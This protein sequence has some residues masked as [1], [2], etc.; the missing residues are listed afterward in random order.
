MNKAVSGVRIFHFFA[1]VYFSVCL[2]LLYYAA[3]YLVFN[4]FT[5][6]AIVSLGIEGFVYYI[7]NKANCPLIHVQ[8]KINDPI[9]FF[10]LF[11]PPK[12]AKLAVPIFSVITIIG[13]IILFWHLLI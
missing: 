11:F 12:L 4:F 7:L 9:P 5:I 10:N 3:I 1:A 2:I 8:K 6:V 13:V